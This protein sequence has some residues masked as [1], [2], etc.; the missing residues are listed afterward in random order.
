MLAAERDKYAAT[1]DRQQE[2][3]DALQ[4]GAE[5]YWEGRWRDANAM[6]DRQRA[7]LEIIAC[8]RQCIDNLM[9][10]KDIALAALAAEPTEPDAGL[11]HGPGWAETQA[12][13]A[14]A[15]SVER[16]F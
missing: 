14:A 16:Y 10:D 4:V 11:A 13:E 8:Q 6:L 9:S 1:L 5:R 12:L 3:I 2:R 7:A 15:R